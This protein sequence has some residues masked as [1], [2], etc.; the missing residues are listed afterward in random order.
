MRSGR[1]KP[2][3][4]AGHSHGGSRLCCPQACLAS[5]AASAARHGGV[6]G[7]SYHPGVMSFSSVPTVGLWGDQGM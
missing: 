4:T 7:F 6:L 5:Q 3:R 2:A 1:C